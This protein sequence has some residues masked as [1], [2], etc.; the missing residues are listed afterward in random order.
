ML[1]ISGLDSLTKELDDAQKALAD[2]DGSIGSVSF[3]PSDPA[4]IERAIDLLP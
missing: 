1:K 2:L 3:D 4:D